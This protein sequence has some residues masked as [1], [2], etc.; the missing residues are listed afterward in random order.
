MLLLAYLDFREVARDKNRIRLYPCI[1]V[2]V[3][4]GN[5][6]VFSTVCFL[7]VCS[8]NTAPSRMGHQTRTQY[9][10]WEKIFG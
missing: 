2:H 5:S 10:D 8:I 6:T 7:D 9:R 4:F 3:L 1:T